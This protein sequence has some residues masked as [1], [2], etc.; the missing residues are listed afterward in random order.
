MTL[1]MPR[2]PCSGQAKASVR[3]SAMPTPEEI[4]AQSRYQLAQTDDNQLLKALIAASVDVVLKA[5]KMASQKLDRLPAQK[6]ASSIAAWGEKHAW[7]ECAPPSI[8]K[9]A[10]IIAEFDR[11]D[12]IASGDC[13]DEIEVAPFEVELVGAEGASVTISEKGAS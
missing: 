4:I 10:D 12:Q 1:D 13:E 2:T 11:R 7:R 9:L 6:R 8:A 5:H 3:P